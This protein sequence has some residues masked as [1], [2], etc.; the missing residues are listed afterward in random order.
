[1]IEHGYRGHIK[2]FVYGGIRSHLSDD[3]GNRYCR[4]YE[5]IRIEQ[6]YP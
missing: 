5:Q 2:L 3:P 1:V 6:K 4:F